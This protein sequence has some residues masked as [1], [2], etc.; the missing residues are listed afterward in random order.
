MWVVTIYS[1]KDSYRD[2]LLGDLLSAKSE[3]EEFLYVVG[4][5]RF[6]NCSS[7]SIAKIFKTQSGAE[8]IVKKF[9]DDINKINYNSKYYW[10]RFKFLSYRKLSESEWLDL[11]DK[12]EA[13]MREKHKK[14]LEKLNI[15]RYLYR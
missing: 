2:G 15:K 8:R 4:N 13:N 1:T 10:I 12:K 6:S 7:I 11:L 3:Y 9:N 14:E 5:N